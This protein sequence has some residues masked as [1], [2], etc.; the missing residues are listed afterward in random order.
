MKRAVVALVAVLALAGCQG[1]KGSPTVT[2]EQRY[3]AG[4]GTSQVFEPG[5]RKKSPTVS[6]T[7]LDGARFTL[8]T[9]KVTVINFWASWC[10]PCRTEADDLEDVYQAGK[11]NGVDFLGIDFRDGKDAAR[12]FAEG[13]MTYPSLFDPAGKVAL[14]F[15][16]VPP[17][18][19]PATIVLDKQ[20]RVAAVIRK[21]VDRD[22]LRKIV[23]P[24]AA[25]Q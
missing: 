1:G 23:D 13:R 4:D 8:A 2:N 18:T 25:E 22:E 21:P 17:N 3:V 11:A 5:Q 12:S 7:L 20:G 6:G 16:D 24:I 19:I 10:A 14:S 9:G 15:R